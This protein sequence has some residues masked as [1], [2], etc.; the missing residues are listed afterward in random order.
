MTYENLKLTKANFVRVDG[1]FYHMSE[2]TDT[3][4]KKV[5]NGENAFSYPLDTN[6][7]SEVKSIQ[8]D[9]RR[10]WTLESSSTTYGYITIRSWEIKDF[11]LKQQRLY[12]FNGQA[13]DKYDCNA[14][15][16]EHYHLNVAGAGG[17]SSPVS[18]GSTTI[19]ITPTGINERLYNGALIY[20]GPSTFP[21]D[22]GQY[23]EVEVEEILPNNEIRVS[24]PIQKSYAYLDTAQVTTRCWLFNKYK[25][26]DLDVNGTGD[27]C[28]F[29]VTY[30]YPT[31]ER[32]KQGNEFRSVVAATYL[33]DPYY[34]SGPR[35]FLMYVNQT[36]LL[37]IET[38]FNKLAYLST[39]ES[40]AQNNQEIDSTII[41]IYGITYEGD[42]LFRLQH[43]GTYRS[44]TALATE[45]WGSDY[46]YQV[47][48]LSRLPQSISLSANP[49]I[50]SAD[51]HSS[52]HL[53]AIVR[54]QFDNPVSSRNVTFTANDTGTGHGVISGT[55]A[56]QT[57][58]L[59]IAYNAYVAGINAKTVIITATA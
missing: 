23:E 56:I 59:G 50:I 18:A 8:H 21:G 31:L 55:G 41:P 5:D 6:I 44:G 20:L 12:Q 19:K 42:T 52:S 28:S 40:A 24:T 13:F 9:G 46:N 30:P 17:G 51:G 25:Q 53:T 37:F 48:V 32:H 47:G 1:Y 33:R 4:Y 57:N 29:E 35:D 45:D 49:A 22:I 10:F 43:K 11:I 27:L 34:T 26:N 39:V 15:A 7:N 2:T 14:F 58:A 36:N 16:I 3:L 54:D 38:D